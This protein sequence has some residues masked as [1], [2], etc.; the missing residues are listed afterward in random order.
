MTVG[1]LS[2]YHLLSAT[3]ATNVMPTAKSCPVQNV[4]GVEAEK[5][6]FRMTGF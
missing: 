6:W 3:L 4:H 2:G 5:A 1:W